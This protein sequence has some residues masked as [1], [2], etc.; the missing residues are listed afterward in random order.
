[1]TVAASETKNYQKAE[2]WVA[3]TVVDG[4]KRSL[5]NAT[6]KLGANSYVYDGR[7]KTP[8]VT[9]MYDEDVL[10]EGKDY[11]VTYNNN[12]NPGTATVQITAVEGSAYRGTIQVF[13][14]IREQMKEN[15]TVIA[16]NAFQ[17]C[18]NLRNVSIKATVSQIGEYAFAD[19]KYLTEIYFYGNKPVISQTAFAN[20]T[21]TAYYPYKDASWNL[22]SLTGYSGNINWV[23]WNPDSGKITGRD[24][25]ICNIQ[26][27][28]TELR[29][30]GTLKTPEVLIHD[31]SKELQTG[32]DYQ[33]SYS[34]NRDTGNAI[35]TIKGIGG[36]GG[37]YTTG[38]SINQAQSVL[39]FSNETITRTY[40]DA[41]FFCTLSKKVTD[42]AVYY[43]SSNTEVASVDGSS[44]KIT[45]RG[46]GTATITAATSGGKNYGKAAAS[47]IIC[48]KKAVNTIKANDITKVYSTKAQTIA[49]GAQVAE[50]AEIR[51]LSSNKKIKVSKNGKVTI[52]KKFIGTVTITISAGE[53]KNYTAVSK[54]VTISVVPKATGLKKA[55]NTGKGKVKITW[56]KQKN[57]SG[58]EI[59]YSLNASFDAGSKTKNVS[60][61][62]TSLMLSKM[63]KKNTYYVRIR[64]YKKVGGKKYYSTWSSV[65]KVL[66]K[67]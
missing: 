47:C 53:T 16:P 38:F 44:G 18:D 35:I 62:K 49:I 40:G 7:A 56:K 39:S 27:K 42:G 32:V 10:V 11:L 26:L 51:Y 60:A 1:M 67:K 25:T 37:I 4:E 17:G 19:C 63:K 65:K 34:N 46:T 55:S 33:I 21:A 9:V 59:Q 3:I 22:E 52:P 41:D 31:G 13:F 14:V 50:G 57:I 8:E 2:T 36:Y 23:P 54:K 28:E 58:Y 29:Y 5:G 43:S 61:S 48:V 20:V 24:I 6:V 30:D 66:I 45:I 15:E 64:T 12:L